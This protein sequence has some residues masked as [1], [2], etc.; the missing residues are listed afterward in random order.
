MADHEDERGSPKDDVSQHGDGRLSRREIVT[1]GLAAVGAGLSP[2]AAAAATEKAAT[3]VG[4]GASGTTA[5]EFR[6]RFAQTGP[7]GEHFI[8]YGYLTNAARVVR[9]RSVCGHAAQRHDR[10]ADRLRGGRARTP[11]GRSERALAR[12]RGH[13]D[14]LSARVARRVLRRPGLVQGGHAGRAIRHHAAGHRDGVRAG[15]GPA[16]ADRRHA[17]DARLAARAARAADGSSAALARESRL[18]ATGLGTLLDPVDVQFLSRDGRALDDRVR[19]RRRAARAVAVVGAGVKTPGGLTVDDLW[20]DAVRGAFDRGR[21]MTS[22]A[23]RADARLLVSRVAGLRPGRLSV[24]GG[25]TPPRPDAPARD[26]GRAGRDRRMCGAPLPPGDRCAVVCG[27]GMGAAAIQEEQHGRLFAAWATEGI[28][29]LA[30]PMMMPNATGGAPV[31]PIRLH[32]AVP[33]RVDG[34]RVGGHRPS[35]KAWS[36][37]AEEPP[38]WCSPAAAIRS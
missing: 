9:R 12:H 38:T 34:V 23:C 8:A 7:T 22:V 4:T 32:R 16:D 3:A 1:V 20:D 28:S 19:G 10:A 37:C 33:H 15:K 27:V 21:P 2:S 18:F 14:G 35:R 17:A 11:D 5:T 26:R 25:A 24:A 6:A 13:A 36:C 30:I 31:A 29:P